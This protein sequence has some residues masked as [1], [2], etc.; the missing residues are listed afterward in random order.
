MLSYRKETITMPLV[1]LAYGTRV[2]KWWVDALFA[3]RNKMRIQTGNN[4]TWQRRNIQHV[5]ETEV[6]Y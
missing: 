4:V 5:T 6:E 3:V 2:I 1:L